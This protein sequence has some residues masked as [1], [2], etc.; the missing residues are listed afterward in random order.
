MRRLAGLS[1][2]VIVFAARAGPANDT[3][4]A[5]GRAELGWIAAPG[6][7]AAVLAA[8]RLVHLVRAGRAI[9]AW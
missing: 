2:G 1:S 7:V 3:Y 5:G 9:R 4:S 8:L 6:V